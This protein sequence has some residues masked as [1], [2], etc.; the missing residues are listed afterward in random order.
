MSFLKK[1]KDRF[2]QLKEGIELFFKGVAYSIKC[3]KTSFSI[4]KELRRIYK[5][6]N[7]N[8]RDEQEHTYNNT[9]EKFNEFIGGG[10]IIDV[11]YQEAH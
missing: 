10:T 8:P 4:A 5:E 11:K 2:N 1:F 7:V 6:Y 9:S 3:G